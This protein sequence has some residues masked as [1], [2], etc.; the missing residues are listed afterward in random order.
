MRRFI[1]LTMV[2]CASASCAPALWEL[3]EPKREAPA[4]TARIEPRVAWANTGYTVRAGE[5]LFFGATGEIELDGLR[6]G[7]D[8][9]KPWIGVRVGRGGLIGRIGPAGE[10]A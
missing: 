5:L 1:L 3:W 9:A 6:V 2:A 8:G 4:A 10:P 7:P